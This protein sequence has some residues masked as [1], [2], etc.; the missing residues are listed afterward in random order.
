M[1]I[2]LLVA[3]AETR[4]GDGPPS[5]HAPPPETISGAFDRMIQTVREVWGGFVGHVPLIVGGLIILVITYGL[6]AL[7][8]RVTDRLLE[9]FTLRPSVK[10]LIRR[11][12]RLAIWLLGLTLAAMIVFPDLSPTDALTALGLVS[13]GLAF[14]DVFENFFA[15]I[16]ILCRFPFLPGDLIERSGIT[17]WVEDITLRNTLIRSPE[18]ELVV[19]PNS[20][21]FK[22]PCIVLTD[23]G[24]RRATVIAGVA[25]GEDVH[26]SREVIGKAVEACETVRD[27]RP[28]GIVAREFASS[29]INFEVTWWTGAE[30]LDIRRSRDEV[31]AAVKRAL[32]E[33]GIEVPFPCRTLTFKEPL[34]TGP[35]E[36]SP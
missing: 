4:T 20:I 19:V 23:R 28:V 35:V 32:D 6:A 9:R 16:L 14:R 24:A 26:A 2:N 1:L 25:Y 30:L 8:R 10:H 27:D 11:F 13:V 15:G 12:V 5:G 21:L 29:S 36:P 31:V 3:A 17:G 18:G 34:R 33:A 7:S 22:D